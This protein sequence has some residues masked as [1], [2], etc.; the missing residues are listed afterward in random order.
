MIAQRIDENHREGEEAH[1]ANRAI[2]HHMR[3]YPE[4]ISSQQKVPSNIPRQP[5]LTLQK[6]AE[7][8]PRA[9]TA[10]GTLWEVWSLRY[11][12][13]AGMRCLH[14]WRC[15]TGSSLR[16]E[17]TPSLLDSALMCMIA[18]D[19]SVMQELETRH[20]AG[21]PFFSSISSPLHLCTAQWC[22]AAWQN[23]GEEKAKIGHPHCQHL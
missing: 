1:R 2:Q 12:A 4:A 3:R 8:Q 22:V 16:H 18:Y 7:K 21:V 14:G 6:K 20:R 17:N 23:M 10:K 11:P 15:S 19:A 9:C 5:K 13:T